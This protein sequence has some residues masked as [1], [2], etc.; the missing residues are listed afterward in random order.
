MQLLILLRDF[1]EDIKA[2]RTRAIL[3][4]VA[5]TWGTLTLILL[6]AFGAGLAFRMKEGLLNAGDRII[7]IYNG[8][9]GKK[10]EGLPIGRNIRLVEEDC[11]IL[12]E[13]I[14]MIGGISPQYGRWGARLRYGDK[15]ATT[16]MEGVYPTFEFL[17][18]MYPA[19]GGRFL[20]QKDLAEKK[21]VVFLGSV[22]AGELLGKEDPI[23]KMI[24]IDGVPFTIV[25][26]MPK[27]LQTAMNNGPDDRRAVIPFSTF[28][29]LYG[30][31][32]LGH[33]LAKPNRNQDSPMIVQE[34]RRVLGKKYKF[35]PTD[36]NALGIWDF[37]DAIKIQNKVF[38]GINIFL[39]VVGAMTLVIAGVGVA[40][41]MYVVVKERTREI[42]IKRA[43]GAKKRD[44]IFQFIFESMLIALVGG[45]LGLL[46]A[47]GIVKLFWMIP[48]QEG[49]MEFLGRPLLSSV[50]VLITIGVLTTIG[51]LAGVFPARKAANVDPVEALRYE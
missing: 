23:G 8:Q 47:L 24:T 10:F 4:T 41:I 27:K 34:V 3:T 18:R 31:R 49:A 9:T 11:S 2:Q 5:I 36:E 26:I 22:I 51:L 43:V 30:Y 17:R 32:Y 50:V 29:S 25:G 12:K 19:A 42:G 14:P 20:N 48:A 7:F 46:I 28:E 1:F 39:A 37:N 21:R 44:I 15:S 33:I 16:Y 13:S 38:L 6:M 35:D 40:N 45:C